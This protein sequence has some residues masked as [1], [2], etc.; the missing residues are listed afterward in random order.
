MASN[1]I[2]YHTD[3]AQAE[4]SVEGKPLP[5]LP[6]ECMP[7]A[8]EASRPLISKKYSTS[9]IVQKMINDRPPLDMEN[10][11]YSMRSTRQRYVKLKPKPVVYRPMIYQPL[12]DWVASQRSQGRK[13]GKSIIDSRLILRDSD[14]DEE[15]FLD[16]LDTYH[17]WLS[18]G[19]SNRSLRSGTDTDDS[20]TESHQT[21]SK[22]SEIGSYDRFSRSQTPCSSILRFGEPPTPP[23]SCP[24]PDIPP[25]AL[26]SDKVTMIQK[27]LAKAVSGAQPKVKQRPKPFVMLATEQ[28]RMEDVT[29]LGVEF[30]DIPRQKLYK[31]SV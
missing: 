14:D 28:K 27:S 22:S 24:L 25:N 3:T 9:P 5:N 11:A 7:S 29:V 8:V 23:P 18:N 21:T 26:A 16:E 13:G 12:P 10:L 20:R 19:T 1:R 2:A 17:M 6:L 31:V 15:I 30:P 4:N